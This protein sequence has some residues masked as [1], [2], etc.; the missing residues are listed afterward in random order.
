MLIKHMTLAEF[1]EEL[2]FAAYARYVRTHGP[3]DCVCRDDGD[4]AICPRYH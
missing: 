2:V 4:N 3:S 1:I